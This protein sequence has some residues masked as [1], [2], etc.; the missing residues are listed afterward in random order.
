V[1]VRVDGRVVAAA[2]ADP[3]AGEI[4]WTDTSRGFMRRSNTDTPLHPEPGAHLVDVNIDA[5]RPNSDWF[6][7]VRL[8]AS[9]QFRAAFAPRVLSTSLACTWVAAGGGRATS[10]TAS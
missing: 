8:L 10:P 4:F 9:P 1:A 3:L 2:V 5:P 7:A 6:D